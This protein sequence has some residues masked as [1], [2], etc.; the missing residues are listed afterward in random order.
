MYRLCHLVFVLQSVPGG[1]TAIKNCLLQPGYVV[2][3]HF[4]YS[5]SFPTSLRQLGLYLGI[6]KMIH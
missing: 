5:T 2:F 1:K 3:S 4:P 6:T